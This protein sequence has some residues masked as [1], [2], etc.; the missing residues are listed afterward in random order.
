MKKKI[1]SE[2]V[3]LF[4]SLLSLDQE[5]ETD[6][7][8]STM[9]E[10][11]NS[12]QNTPQPINLVLP[13]DQE[14]E[15]DHNL[16]TIDEVIDSHPNMSQSE[17]EFEIE[18]PVEDSNL[19]SDPV[20][21][22]NRI[23]IDQTLKLKNEKQRLELEEKQL[24]LQ[25]QLLQE[26]K[27]SEESAVQEQQRLER[28]LQ[29]DVLYKDVLDDLERMKNTNSF[30]EKIQ[31]GDQVDKLKEELMKLHQEAHEIEAE[32]C[33]DNF[34]S[35]KLQNDVEKLQLQNLRLLKKSAKLDLSG[36]KNEL[37]NL[38]KVNTQLR[39]TVLRDRTCQLKLQKAMTQK[40]LAKM[41]KIMLRKSEPESLESKPQFQ[42]PSEEIIEL[43]KQY[44]MRELHEVCSDY[45]KMSSRLK[46]N[47]L[48]TS[49]KAA[50]S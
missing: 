33:S 18:Q 7:N 47:G 44:Q 39:E 46:N 17:P 16:R 45:Q 8:I 13:P 14:P 28:L 35:K 30:L 37:E 4:E 10:V 27:K 15:T 11:D 9:E 25:E 36:L 29:E 41:Q 3:N 21:T 32:E 23:E 49:N 20:E 24:R 42:F 40:H 34:D 5:P 48:P 26:L 2:F 19:Y 1:L 38:Q 43:D 31:N 6:Q 12:P 50:D 22:I